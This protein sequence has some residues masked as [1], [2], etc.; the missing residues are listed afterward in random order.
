[1]KYRKIMSKAKRQKLKIVDM[2]RVLG[3]SKKE[4]KQKLK[5]RK[6]LYIHELEALFCYLGIEKG[7][8]KI[9]FF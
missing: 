2:A 7:E 8:E 9:K 5:G 4:L 3:V 6:P 1:M